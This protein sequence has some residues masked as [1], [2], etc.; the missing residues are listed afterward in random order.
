MSEARIFCP[1][2]IYSD[3]A[4]Q[5]SDWL[6]EKWLKVHLEELLEKGTWNKNMIFLWPPNTMETSPTLG[7]RNLA[8]HSCQVTGGYFE[9]WDTS[10]FSSRMPF[11]AFHHRSSFLFI[12]SVEVGREMLRLSLRATLCW[13]RVLNFL[14][15]SAWSRAHTSA[16]SQAH[17]SVQSQIQVS[18]VVI[19]KTKQIILYSKNGVATEIVISSWIFAIKS[20]YFWKV[21][22]DKHKQFSFE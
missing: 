11:P 10:L 20:R 4:I 12:S 15:T 16:C 3:P 9:M 1:V 5:C 19:T 6:G 13:T 18:D 7:W 22:E 21:S 2:N 17:T 8:Q 14:H